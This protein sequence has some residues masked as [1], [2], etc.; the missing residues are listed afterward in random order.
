G[1]RSR[2][3]S[4]RGR[5]RGAARP[6]RAGQPQPPASKHRPRA[7][8]R[9]RRRH[10]ARHSVRVSRT[11]IAS[12]GTA[13]RNRAG[14]GHVHVYHPK[15]RTS[16]VRTVT[17]TPARNP[18]RSFL[19]VAVALLFSGTLA[20]PSASASGQIFFSAVTNVTDIL[21]QQI[22]AERV[23]IDVGIWYLSEGS[24]SIAIANRW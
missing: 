22:N 5:R 12:P 11:R 17:V 18:R 24:V 16:Q 1:G 7:L 9:T 20:T 4:P 19:G 13:P 21:V 23:R 10:R 8:L 6:R 3:R 2:R 14:R 15:T